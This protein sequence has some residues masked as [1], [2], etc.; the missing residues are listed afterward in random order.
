VWWFSGGLLVGG[1]STAFV[2]VVLGALTLRP[3][4]PTPVAVGVMIAVVGLV[5]LNEFGVVRLP[6]P[7]NARQVP[8]SVGD[9]GDRFGPLQFGFE[10]GTGLRT[11]MTSG[12]PHAL[13]TPIVLLAGWQEGLAAGIAFGAGRAWMTL[14][15]YAYPEK[16]AWDSA[17]RRQ[18]RP[19]RVSL[20]VVSALAAAQIV[21]TTLSLP[22]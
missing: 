7:Q 19:I 6:L 21:H 17:L 18:D 1:A 12:L 13:I 10:M 9:E 2:G 22:I 5:A 16:I 20:T 14:S 8:E 11:Y 15:R 3:L 4:V